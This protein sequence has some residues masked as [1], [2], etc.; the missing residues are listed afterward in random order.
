MS[1]ENTLHIHTAL[2]SKVQSSIHLLFCAELL[3]ITSVGDHGTE[4]SLPF[5]ISSFTELELERI[6][7][8]S[9]GDTWDFRRLRSCERCAWRQGGQGGG[10]QVKQEGGSKPTNKLMHKNVDSRLP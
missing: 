4:K 5:E 9:A 6:I 7:N 8:A 3:L 2:H 10:A 1:L